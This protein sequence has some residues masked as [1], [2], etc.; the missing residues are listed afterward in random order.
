MRNKLITTFLLLAGVTLTVLLT[1]ASEDEILENQKTFDQL[2]PIAEA[3]FIKK[4]IEPLETGEDYNLIYSVSYIP[5]EE[6]PSELGL[7][8][9]GSV[10]LLLKDDG[11]YPDETARDFKYTAYF[12]ENI[13]DLIQAIEQNEAKLTADGGVLTFRGHVGEYKSLDDIIKFDFQAFASG[14]EVE[15]DPLIVNIADCET[16]LLKQNSLFITDLSVV[17]DPSRTFKM[18]HNDPKD[19]PDLGLIPA[20]GNRVGAWT[21]GQLMK[22][23]ANTP[24]TGV[25]TKEFLRE[26]LRQ[27]ITPDTIGSF[28]HGANSFN[29]T[30]AN[31][32]GRFKHNSHTGFKALIGDWIVK[33]R[34]SYDTSYNITPNIGNWDTEWNGTNE[35]SLLVYAPFKLMAIVNRLDL[36]GGTAY[37]NQISNA[38]ETRFI[39]TLIDPFT[40]YPPAHSC[41]GADNNNNSAQQFTSTAIDWVGMNVILEFGNPMTSNCELHDFA[42]DWYQLSDHTLGSPAYLTALQAITDQVVLSGAGGTKNKNQSCINQIRTNE[43]IASQVECIYAPGFGEWNKASW[44]LRQFELVAGTNGDGLLHGTVLTNT[45]VDIADGFSFN[46]AP[47]INLPQSSE[48]DISNPVLLWIYGNN[49][50]DI[51][52]MR[53]NSGMYNLPEQFLAGAASIHKESATH[54]DFDWQNSLPLNAKN[55]LSTFF[56]NNADV[57]NLLAKNIR[58]QVSLNTCQGCH[59]GETKTGFTQVFPRGYGQPA[60]YWDPIPSVVEASEIYIPT[61]IA[62]NPAIPVITGTSLDPRFGNDPTASIQGSD[63]NT[64]FTYNQSTQANV[65]NANFIAQVSNTTHQVVSPFIT[66]RRYTTIDNMVSWQDDFLDDNQEFSFLPLNIQLTTTVI[67]LDQILNGLFYVNDPANKASTTTLLNGKGGKFPQRHNERHGFN[68]LEKRHLDLCQ[69]LNTN[70]NSPGLFSLIFEVAFLPAPIGSH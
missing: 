10:Y 49:G 65:L 50:S 16:E 29:F 41:I 15:L 63:T 56:N 38:G 19:N 4:I 34:Q 70:C 11:V 23:M 17:E 24:V 47:N 27:F 42:N 2:P 39:F 66:G 32:S 64:E 28:A 53:V 26:W 33:A 30:Y 62:G 45:P 21:F 12:N 60:N 3:F 67:E 22:N 59:S 35:D 69:F 7:L 68:E 40:G 58:H 18:S 8:R 52:R 31:I 6:L 36:R 55:N 46:E 48:T 51:N 37:T 57:A 1:S 5:D 13:N 14:E 61:P 44:Q 9:D 43:K 20:S 25:T 54:F